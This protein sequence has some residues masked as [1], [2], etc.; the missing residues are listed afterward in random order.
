MNDFESL[1]RC[2]RCGANLS[3]H[4][5]D[6]L[7][8]ACLFAVAGDPASLTAETLGSLS[9]LT[10][11]E[12]K[13]RSSTW[14]TPGQ[15]FGPYHI[16]RLLGRGGMGEVYE[17][18]HVEQGRRVALK[19]LNQR[20]DG[21][22][23]RARFLREGELA[24]SINHP[25]SVY[26]FGSEEIDGTA[27]IAME[28][29]PGGTL[30]DLVRDRGPLGPAEAVDAV[31]QV[32]AGLDAMQ[33]AGVLHRDVKPANC[34]VDGDGTVKIGDFGLSISTMARDVSQLTATGTFHGTPQFAAPEQL[35]GDPLDVRADIYAVGATL[36]YL[37]TGRAPFDDR[38]LLTLVTRIATDSPPSPRA[39]APAVPRGLAAVVLRC[40]AKDRTL[41]PATYAALHDVLKPFSSAAPSAARIGVRLVAGV[42]D[43]IILSSPLLLFNVTLMVRSGLVRPPWWIAIIPIPI[44]I[45]YFGISEGVWGA[46]IGKRLMRLRVVPASGGQH[47]PGVTRA[48]SRALVL[49]AP[50]VLLAVAGLLFQE[51]MLRWLSGSAWLGLV[52][53]LTVWMLTALMFATAR[54]R[55]G[56]AGVHD[57]WS[58][59][60]VV[61]RRKEARRPTLDGA[62]EPAITIDAARR[63]IGPFDVIGSLG[64]TEAGTLLAGFDPRLRRRVWIHELA[65]DTPPVPQRERDLNRPGRLRWL[66]G[67][68]A[69]ADNWDAYEALDGRAFVTMLDRPLSWRVIRPWLADLAQEIEAGLRD[70]SLGRL[71]LD[72]LWI[73]GAG[74]AKLLEFRAPAAPVA[75]MPIPAASEK[76]AQTF[77]SDVATSALTGRVSQ[78]SPDVVRRPRHALPMSATALLDALD[79][80]GFDSWPEVVRRVGA[81]L[82]GPDR[83]GRRRRALTIALSVALPLGAVLVGAVLNAVFVPAITRAIPQEIQELSSALRALS[84]QS[85]AGGSF[86]R[87]ALETYIAGR[88]APTLNDPQLWTNP[89]TVG[90]LRRD[91]QLIERIMADHPSVSADQLAAATA[92]LGPFL[93]RQAELQT[94]SRSISPWTITFSTAPLFFALA[95]VVGVV[96]AWLFRGGMFLRACDIAVVTKDGKSISR[97]RALW[98]GLAAWSF[99]PVA[100]W[101][102]PL[103]FALSA[104]LVGP[105]LGAGLA[106]SAVVVALIGTVWAIVCPERGLQDRVA[107]TY[108]VPR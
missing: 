99:V 21:V 39:L 35:K 85:G 80:N 18:E 89:M 50:S 76:S 97:I 54:Q 26:I 93:A 24:A 70:E 75:S 52:A 36:Y 73:T 72:R 4:A 49:N 27:V 10:D 90:F 28:L 45:A 67:H 9:P 31:L 30:K 33:A 92:A 14:P 68:R 58:G 98:R 37:L 11:A 6:G 87:S 12:G 69:S 79:R 1:T 77:L 81:L 3:A 60:R 86:D 32:I 63:R 5:P 17:A 59:T 7:C 22:D 53:T 48:A 8:A 104:G 96:S 82:N 40:L 34:F 108:L 38:N 47:P 78:A 88:F 41:R 71:T 94:Y 19:V 103:P 84:T 95:A 100:F 56:F 46:S 23:G 44:W 2:S 65:P 106:L 61:E 42:I 91:R 57:L 51:P 102:A 66:G 83:V 25:H 107:D 15:M 16:E 20:L 105:K 101:F 74:R 62:L 43:Y 55:N 29:L 13:P 64:P